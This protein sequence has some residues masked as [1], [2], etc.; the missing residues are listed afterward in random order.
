MARHQRFTPIAEWH[1]VALLEKEGKK[2]ASWLGKEYGTDGSIYLMEK[3]SGSTTIGLYQVPPIE[4]LSPEQA[5]KEAIE[6]MTPEQ[7]A[8]PASWGETWC[9]LAKRSDP[10][11]TPRYAWDEVAGVF[12]EI[13]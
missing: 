2:R 4:H 7:R 11:P 8:R 3:P 12:V 9:V 10:P 1:G 13:A 6:K 5:A